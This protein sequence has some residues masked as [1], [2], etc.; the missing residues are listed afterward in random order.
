MTGCKTLLASARSN[1]T[2]E[3]V[4]YQADVMVVYVGIKFDSRRLQQTRVPSA[5]AR[6][7]ESVNFL[8]RSLIAS[9]FFS[10]L[11]LTF[12]YE[13]R[14]HVGVCGFSPRTHVGD[15][16]RWLA[17]WWVVPSSCERTSPQDDKNKL[18]LSL[19][20]FSPLF[21]PFYWVFRTEF[22]VSTI[23]C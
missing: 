22:L 2:H 19:R 21:L 5:R 8:Q 1:Q 15:R 20:R 12:V 16:T 23:M 14:A 10:R 7:T 13:L 4:V 6:P 17:L 11:V 9:F 3:L 18:Q